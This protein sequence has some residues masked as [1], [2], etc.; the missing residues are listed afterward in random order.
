MLCF[1]VFF[2]S[3]FHSVAQAGLEVTVEHNLNS[4]SWRSSCL[5]LPN[6]RITGVTQ[7]SRLWKGSTSGDL[8]DVQCGKASHRGGT[9]CS[10]NE[11]LSCTGIRAGTWNLETVDSEYLPV[12]FEYPKCSQY[13][14]QYPD[15]V[16]VK[17]SIISYPHITSASNKAVKKPWKL[18]KL[19]E[20]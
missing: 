4:N 6:A 19:R 18:N 9:Y 13:S 20:I 11:H 5:K 17:T 7:H 14:I 2:W 10:Q 8:C 1:F 15:S 3:Q 16:S 12:P